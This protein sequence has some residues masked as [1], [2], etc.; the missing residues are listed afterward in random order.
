MLRKGAAKDLDETMRLG[1]GSTSN[2]TSKQKALSSLLVYT[3][4][5]K[6]M[7]SYVLAPTE[8]VPVVCVPLAMDVV[9]AS[10][11]LVAEAVNDVE[12]GSP[13]TVS[14]SLRSHCENSL[15]VTPWARQVAE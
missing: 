10:R 2:Q 15:I 6:K 5:S 3:T 1:L 14:T 13:I 8:L 11:V 9:V 7:L 12:V 4:R